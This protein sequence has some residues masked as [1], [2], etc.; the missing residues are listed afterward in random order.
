MHEDQVV[1]AIDRDDL[2][3]HVG[4][5]ERRSEDGSD[6]HGAV[7]RRTMRRGAFHCVVLNPL[8]TL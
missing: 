8:L 6:H 2:A 5:R 7:T 4:G 3:V 1:G